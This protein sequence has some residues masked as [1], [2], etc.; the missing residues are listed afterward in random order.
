MF[1][2]FISTN[3]AGYKATNIITIRVLVLQMNELSLMNI[4]ELN[5]EFSI[6][7]EK[8]QLYFK[9][10]DGG[11]AVVEI[12]NA[13]ASARISLQGAHV[14]SWKPCDE[15]EVIW[16]SEEATF[17][18]G[19]S[20]RGGIP[21]CWPWFGAHESNPLFPAHGFARTVIWQVV[22]T[23][24]L[25]TNETQIIFRLDINELDEKYKAMWPLETG[26][27]YCLTIGKELI[28]QLTTSNNSD[29]VLTV[30]QALHTYFSIGDISNTSI[31]GLEDKTFLDKVEGF[32]S[33]IQSGFITINEEVD[34]VYLDTVDDVTIDNIKR[35]IRIKKKGSSS[36]VVWNPWEEV[37]N[38]MGDLGENGYRK[39][40]CVESANA[41]SDVVK[42]KPHEKFSLSVTYE[43]ESKTS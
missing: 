29:E 15:D 1:A 14:L 34:R 5:K 42:I 28:L 7:N 24:Y 31:Y 13:K 36:T 16:L 43:I 41:M 37:A 30:G 20:V 22:D 32:N 23:Q 4:E 3:I 10:G 39:M 8:S 9:E 26:L 11:I 33:K 2:D 27:E 25:S 38:K 6:D 40:V 19:K 12:S 18:K 17:S 35:K 21:I